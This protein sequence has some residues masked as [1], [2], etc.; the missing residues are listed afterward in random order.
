MAS[1]PK[2]LEGQQR[3]HGAASRNHPR[4][5]EPR[6]LKDPVEGDRGE[7]RHE[8]KQATELGTERCGAQV[9]LADIGDIGDG[10]PGTRWAFVVGPARQPAESLA[11][12][13]VSD[14]D[15]TEAVSFMSQVAADVID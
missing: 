8:E 13:D 6:V 2:Q 3:S 5:G 1:R 4:A 7:H 11:L 14:S 10:R 12:E 15:R 9:K